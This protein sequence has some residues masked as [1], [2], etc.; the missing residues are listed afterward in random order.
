[1]VSAAGPA[2]LRTR[3][4]A[5][6]EDNPHRPTRTRTATGNRAQQQRTERQEPDGSQHQRAQPPVDQQCGDGGSGDREHAEDKQNE[7]DAATEPAASGDRR[8]LGVQDVVG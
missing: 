3:V 5:P 8:D 7:V 2:A 1:M 6:P 4:A